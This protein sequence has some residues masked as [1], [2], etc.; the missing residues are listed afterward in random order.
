K[1]KANVSMSKFSKPDQTISLN[2]A[3]KKG[4]T[5][6][7]MLFNFIETAGS[8]RNVAR[9]LPRHRPDS[10]KPVPPYV[11]GSAR[12]LNRHAARSRHY[13]DETVQILVMAL[14]DKHPG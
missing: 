13:P 4:Q 9:A 3:L 14:F 7:E 2:I 12:L 5:H 11:Y 6:K 1:A 10:D 8:L